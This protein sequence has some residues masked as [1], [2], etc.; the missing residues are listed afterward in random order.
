[1]LE[2]EKLL[3]N[4]CKEVSCIT[5][6][7]IVPRPILYNNA[8]ILFLCTLPFALFRSEPSLSD[9]SPSPAAIANEPYAMSP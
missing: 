3:M 5:P 1:M 9:S 2:R 7:A 4:A 8:V 6:N